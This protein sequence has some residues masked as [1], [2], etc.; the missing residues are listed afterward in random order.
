[1]PRSTMPIR[2][3]AR[4]SANG[5]ACESPVCPR[6]HVQRTCQVEPSP[7]RRPYVWAQRPDAGGDDMSV[8]GHSVRR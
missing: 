5:C 2:T 7:W 4:Q 3:N 6:P 1:M 8:E